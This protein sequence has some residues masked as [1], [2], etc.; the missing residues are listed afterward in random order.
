MCQNGYILDEFLCQY[1]MVNS[2]LAGMAVVMRFENHP[3]GTH[4]EES[5]LAC[6]RDSWGHASSLARSGETLCS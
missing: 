2:S 5:D 6:E 4:L 1:N 3:E